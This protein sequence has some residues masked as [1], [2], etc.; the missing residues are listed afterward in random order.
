[1]KNVLEPTPLIIAALIGAF[2][3]VGLA[4][5]SEDTSSSFP[6]VAVKGAG[7]GLA[8]QIGVRL[9]GVS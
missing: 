1:M 8:V 3:L 4:V 2:V 9:F 5:M 6:M 7:V